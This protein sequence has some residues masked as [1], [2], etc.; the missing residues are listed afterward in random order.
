MNPRTEALVSTRAAVNSD[1]DPRSEVKKAEVR[2]QKAEG[3]RQ[4]AVYF[5]F[6]VSKFPLFLIFHFSL[7]L[8]VICHLS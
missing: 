8:F 5:L 7:S 3:R 1:G 6:L 2:R 4:K